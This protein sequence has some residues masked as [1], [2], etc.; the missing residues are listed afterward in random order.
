MKSYII[1]SRNPNTKKLLVIVD[2]D[3]NPAE[4]SSEETAL[5]VAEKHNVCQSWG[6]DVVL[7]DC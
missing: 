6:S 7:I 4:F 5:D 1:V 2:E 3:G